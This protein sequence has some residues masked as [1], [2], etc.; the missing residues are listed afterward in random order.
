MGSLLEIKNVTKIFPLGGLIHKK[1]VTAVENFSLEIPDDRQVITTLAGESGS[2][3][4]Q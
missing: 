3:K 1:S 4:Q 2:G